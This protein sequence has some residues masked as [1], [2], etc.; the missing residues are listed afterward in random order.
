MAGAHFGV[1]YE[2]YELFLEIQGHSEALIRSKCTKIHWGTAI[3]LSLSC[4]NISKMS[5]NS[6][7][8]VHSRGYYIKL[9]YPMTARMTGMYIEFGTGIQMYAR[10]SHTFSSWRSS[11]A[12]RHVFVSKGKP[13]QIEEFLAQ[14]LAA[15]VSATSPTCSTQRLHKPE[16]NCMH[17]NSPWWWRQGR[18]GKNV[19]NI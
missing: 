1:N 4:W 10:V 3:Y 17:V 13:E 15:T 2:V 6:H 11:I 12:L 7:L 5:T 9:G 19:L 14:F 18:I 16:V 8:T